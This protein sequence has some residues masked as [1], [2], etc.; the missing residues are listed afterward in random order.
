VL[1]T[2]D[3]LERILRSAPFN[4]ILIAARSIET[5]RHQRL[6]AFASEHGIGIAHFERAL[7]GSRD[8]AEPISIEDLERSLLEPAG[9]R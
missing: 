3:E 8:S 7:N 5:L 4:R 2:L 6:E 1:G 9:G